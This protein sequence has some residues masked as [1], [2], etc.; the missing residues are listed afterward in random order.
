MAAT[1]TTKD[2][3]TFSDVAAPYVLM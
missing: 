3:V 1:D 2:R